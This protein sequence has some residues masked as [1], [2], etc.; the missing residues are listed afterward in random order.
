L[1]QPLAQKWGQGITSSDARVD[2]VP[3]RALN[4]TFHP[5]YLASA[6]RGIKVYTHIS[7]LWIPCYLSP[8]LRRH[9]GLYGQYN[10]DVRRFASVPAAENFSY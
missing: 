6:G 10:F 7:D 3:V 8:L 2:G 5:K 1:Q 9:L 4:A